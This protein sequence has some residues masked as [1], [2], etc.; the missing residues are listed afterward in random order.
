MPQLDPATYA[1]QI[2]WLAICFFSLYFVF[3]KFIIPK[4]DIVLDRRQKIIDEHLNK[5]GGYKEK[6]ENLAAAY[7][8]AVSDARDK[9][10]A[11]FAQS[12]DE[13]KAFIGEKT[14]DLQKE[15]AEQLEKMQADILRNK[16]RAVAETDRIAAELAA[17]VAVKLGLR[18]G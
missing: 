5:A 17:V 8:K 3:A 10:A 14:V 2:F 4:M 15:L 18:N 11:H 9:A 12:S 13:L 1:S 16:A 7:D 6:A